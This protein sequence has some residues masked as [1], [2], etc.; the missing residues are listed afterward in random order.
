MGSTTHDGR[1][2]SGHYHHSRS[3][4]GSASKITDS[5]L[6]KGLDY[7][8]DGDRYRDRGDFDKAEARYRKA[9][10]FYPSEARDRLTILPL[11]K[12]SKAPMENSDS[13]R[14][15]PAGFRARLHH[16]KEKVMQV[17]KEPSQITTPHQYF[18]P[19]STQST[20][21]SL[22]NT[23]SQSA[24]V[25]ASTCMFTSTLT[26]QSTAE[27]PSTFASEAV[28]GDVGTLSDV[29]SLAAAYKI[30]DSKTKEIIDNKVY[31][32]IKEFG[33]S[34]VTFDTMQELVA[35]ADIQDR[36]IFLHVTTKI[37]DVLRNMPLLTSIALQGL[38]VI[39]D[40]FPDTIDLSS[41]QGTFVEI[42]KPLQD[43]L[44]GIR[45]ANNIDELLP[46]LIA[47]SSLLD[48]M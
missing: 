7:I 19:L 21:A 41:L 33:E 9:V 4:S 36:D 16:V 11:C 32:I 48:A 45:T 28:V 1:P 29:R 8:K 26:T 37:L 18:F 46:L 31:D 12:A 10:G 20:L 34:R 17:A 27:T 14:S 22:A 42:L 23:D 38:A 3:I 24:S 25:S 6:Q 30:A 44:S 39:L 40:S 15:I 47:L 5:Q 2:G 35:L 43:R 13:N